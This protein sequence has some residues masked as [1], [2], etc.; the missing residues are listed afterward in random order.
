MAFGIKGLFCEKEKLHHPDRKDRARILT[1]RVDRQEDA[2]FN[3]HQHQKRS[4]GKPELN[5]PT[6]TV[7]NAQSESSGTRAQ[8][9]LPDPFGPTH[10]ISGSDD[11]Q[12]PGPSFRTTMAGATTPVNSWEGSQD[13]KWSK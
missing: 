12:T 13:T 7:P 5:R 8:G 9:I 10:L 3:S 6:G 2:D 1:N 11:S 4:F